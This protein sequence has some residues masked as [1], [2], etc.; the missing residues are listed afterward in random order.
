[1]RAG[2]A[3]TIVG[4]IGYPWLAIC[5]A[6]SFVGAAVLIVQMRIAPF[7]P[8]ADPQASVAA[9]AL[10]TAG[11]GGYWQVAHD[12][13]FLGFTATNVAFSLIALSSSL[14]LPVY[15][16]TTLRQPAWVVSALFSL[17]TLLIT[18][19]Q[20]VV[21]RWIARYRRTHAL[22]GSAA[23]FGLSF[24]VLATLL[25]MAQ[26]ESALPDNATGHAQAAWALIGGLVVAMGIFTLAELIM[27]PLKN[28]LVADAASDALRGRYLAFYHLSWS[29][30]STV[31]PALLTGLLAYN[32]LYLWLALAVVALLALV[33]LWRLDALLP[34]HAVRPRPRP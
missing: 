1:M 5:N 22:M 7:A 8:Q 19:L 10:Q 18:T 31:A 32:P 14:A 20:L 9:P 16:V 12:G 34:A 28:A 11:R 25:S 3:I 33:S 30:A 29:V 2:A 21:V 23:L 26:G 4:I 13:P 24:L 6:L 17:N 27:A 15:I